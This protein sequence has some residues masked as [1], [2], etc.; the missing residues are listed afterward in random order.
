M[1]QKNIISF[2]N[3]KIVL[4]RVQNPEFYF[5]YADTQTSA[6]YKFKIKKAVF[7][8]RKNK[9]RDSYLQFWEQKLNA[10]GSIRYNFKDCRCFSRT[11]AGLPSE[12]I[13][14][15]LCHSILPTKL[16]F[17]FVDGDAFRGINQKTRFN[18]PMFQTKFVKSDFL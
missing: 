3:I 16:Y 2:C 4:N 13:E 9:I 12:I 14:D 18:L 8:V 15:N 11:Y 10:G 1:S 17:G 7:R 6:P 5:R